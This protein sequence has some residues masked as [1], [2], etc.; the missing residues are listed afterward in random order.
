MKTTRKTE[1]DVSISNSD[2]STHSARVLSFVYDD[3]HRL[4]GRCL[5]NQPTDHTL[6]PTALVHEV[7]LRLAGHPDYPWEDKA[8]FFAVGAQAMRNLLVDYARRRAAAKRGGNQRKLPIHD[9][10]EPS[11]YRDRYLID[12]D[13]ALTDLASVDSQLCKLV[14]LRFF[15]GLSIEETATVLGVSPT[16]VKRK[17]KVARCWLHHEITRGY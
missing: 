2:G 13:D 6:Q 7:Y 4:A 17:W 3:L 11:N 12:L 14:E 10:L 9:I 1:P 8:E 16:T 5:R 15:G